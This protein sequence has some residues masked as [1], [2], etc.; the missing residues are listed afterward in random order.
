MLSLVRSRLQILSK[1]KFNSH[2][3]QMDLES[4]NDFSLD[5]SPV[6]TEG[7]A[8]KPKS[9]LDDRT[10]ESLNQSDLSLEIVLETQYRLEEALMILTNSLYENFLQANYPKFAKRYKVEQGILLTNRGMYEQASEI[11]V[12]FQDIDWDS[13][14]AI[15]LLNLLQCYLN[16]YKYN[17]SVS[18]AVKL[19]KL[20]NTLSKPT[21]SKLWKCV[22]DISHI[23]YPHLFPADDLFTTELL[24]PGIKVLQGDIIEA[25]LKVFSKIP[26]TIPLNKAYSQFLSN[27]D[28][29]LIIL[30]GL[31]IKLEPGKNIFKISGVASAQGKMRNNKIYLLFNKLTLIINTNTTQINIEENTKS[32]SLIHK[33]PSLLVFNEVQLLAIEI[34]TRQYSI[35]TG[36]IDLSSATSVFFYLDP[37]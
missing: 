26:C 20:S 22:E 8:L 37:L 11:L 29:G 28:K 21:I 19:C 10:I 3:I 33:V 9:L 5:R 23:N 18:A 24:I 34:S 1:M 27:K 15:V 25:T 17:E 13:L 2:E 30:E 12:L 14:Q 31:N 36:I 4:V 35:D 7:R 16:T 32:V 6:K